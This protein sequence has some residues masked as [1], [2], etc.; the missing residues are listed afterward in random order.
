MSLKDRTALV[1]RDILVGIDGVREFV[2]GRRAGGRN[3]LHAVTVIHPSDYR[4]DLNGY[5]NTGGP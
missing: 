5:L 2:C 3:G 4:H 1:V